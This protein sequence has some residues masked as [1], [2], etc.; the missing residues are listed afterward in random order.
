[1]TPARLTG[2]ASVTDPEENAMSAEVLKLAPAQT[3]WKALPRMLD[4]TDASYKA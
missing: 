1:L 3:E 2:E 4:K